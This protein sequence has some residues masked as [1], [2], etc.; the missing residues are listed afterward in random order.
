MGVAKLFT[1]FLEQ[2]PYRKIGVHATLKNDIFQINGT[3]KEDGK[4]YLVRRGALWGVDV[5]NQSTDNRASFRDMVKR[6]KRVTEGSEGPV[7][8]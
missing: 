3:I 1:S 5:I 6:I 2:F 8:E 4:E 7:V